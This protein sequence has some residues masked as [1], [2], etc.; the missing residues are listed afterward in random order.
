ML[1]QYIAGAVNE[2]IVVVKDV[3]WSMLLTASAVKI[4]AF[5][6]SLGAMHVSVSLKCSQAAFARFDI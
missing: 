1:Y 5:D 2:L 6:V 3:L 4:Q